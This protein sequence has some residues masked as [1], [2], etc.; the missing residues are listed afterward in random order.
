MNKKVYISGPLIG[1]QNYMNQLMQIEK[2]LEEKGYSVL[3]SVKVNA[4]LPRDTLYM[5]HMK[6][7]MTMM[8]MADAIYLVP[9]WEKVRGSVF[10][11]EY[12]ES[13]GLEFLNGK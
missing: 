11:L 3:N 1:N 5:D 4:Q 7:N 10:D 13:I 8:D 6:M 9:G 12:A 2:M